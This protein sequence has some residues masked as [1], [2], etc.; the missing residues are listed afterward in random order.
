MRLTTWAAAIF[1]TAAVLAATTGTNA[2]SRYAGRYTVQRP[3]ADS[4]QLLILVLA[5]N[6]RASLTTRYVDL[7]RGIGTSVLPIAEVGSWRERGTTAEV[8]F[9]KFGLVRDGKMMEPKRD[10]NVITFALQQR[11]LLRAVRYSKV[12]YGEAGLSMDKTGCR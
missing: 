7:E 9:T 2:A 8:R 3:G 4:M 5:P 1:F 6:G 12:T 11:C 10:N